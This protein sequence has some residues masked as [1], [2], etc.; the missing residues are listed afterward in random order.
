MLCRLSPLFACLLA[1]SLVGLPGEVAT[2]QDEKSDPFWRHFDERFPE[3]A[4]KGQELWDKAAEIAKLQI[5][6]ADEDAFATR[7]NLVFQALAVNERDHAIMRKEAKTKAEHEWILS[8]R[9]AN[10]QFEKDVET[11]KALRAKADGDLTQ[12]DMQAIMQTTV[13]LMQYIYEAQIQANESY[14][15]SVVQSNEELRE[16]LAEAEK[17]PEAQPK[18]EPETESNPSGS[19]RKAKK[20][21]FKAY[22]Q[23][24]RI[25]V[26]SDD[27]RSDHDTNHVQI[28]GAI[29]NQTDKPAR[30]R[31]QVYGLRADKRVVGLKTITTGVIP[32]GGVEEIDTKMAVE[33]SAYVRSVDMRDVTV[34]EP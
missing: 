34:I 31:F 20:G 33:H 13:S 21:D 16:K 15:E 22:L 5:D 7:Q 6:E 18:P 17:Q 8:R 9:D 29:K 1:L 26:D 19:S 12:A 32:P 28:T 23:S 27:R 14:F 10:R 25:R 4:G 30:F 11:M 24:D 3:I 2:A